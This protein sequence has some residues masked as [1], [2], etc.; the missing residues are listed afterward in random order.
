MRGDAR[1]VRPLIR[2]SYFMAEINTTRRSDYLFTLHV[3]S[4][5]S[6]KYRGY[7]AIRQNDSQLESVPRYG[8]KLDIPDSYKSHEDLVTAGNVLF[9]RYLK[10]EVSVSVPV[11]KEKLRGYRI[12]GSARFQLFDL[13]WE[14]VLELKKLEEP[15]KGK[16]QTVM[17]P[18]TAFARN[19]FQSAESAAT[20]AC[21]FGKRMV[22]GLV[23]GLE[24]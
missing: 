5:Q 20:F 13:K 22:I 21:D 3:I 6:N 8:W 1:S 17:G 2:F 7:L 11:V 15:N 14:P 9:S 16:K 19:L 12:V 4:K 10:Y 23:R 18:D 24:I